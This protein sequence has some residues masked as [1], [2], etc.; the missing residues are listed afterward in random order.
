MIKTLQVDTYQSGHYL[1]V[2]AM[3]RLSEQHVV[4]AVPLMIP[5]LGSSDPVV[6]Y[7]TVESLAELGDASIGAFLMP[8]LND[9]E[10]IVRAEAVEALGRLRYQP[11]LA[12]LLRL[13]KQESE[14][15]VM[16]SIAETLGD[17]QDVSAVATLLT[18]LANED[19]AVRAYAANSLGLIGGSDLIQ[20]LVIYAKDEVALRV[21][22]ELWGAIYRLGEQAALGNILKLLEDADEPLATPV[23]NLLVDLLQWLD[24]PIPQQDAQALY[25]AM[26]KLKQ[27]LPIVQHHAQEVIDLLVK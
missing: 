1:Q 16:A 2:E 20:L 21:K 18:F 23:L 5:F 4:D 24:R 6:R 19:E 17:F 22:A 3:T 13:A 7:T 10:D 12:S 9:P 26:Q 15:L 11:A 27:Q 25:K 8:L 14:P